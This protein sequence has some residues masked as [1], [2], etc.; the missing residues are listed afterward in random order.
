M[1]YAEDKVICLAELDRKRNVDSTGL[2]HSELS[3]DPHVAAFA[4]V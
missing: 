3:D 1:L 4:E 2:E